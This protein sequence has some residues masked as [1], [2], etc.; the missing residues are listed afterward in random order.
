MSS[1]KSLAK[2]LPSPIRRRLGELRRRL[3]SSPSRTEAQKQLLLAD[4]ALENWQRELLTNVSSRIFYDDGMY[5]GDG[6]HY[7]KVGLSAIRCIDEA[8]RDA[9]LDRAESI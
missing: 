6:A 4:P 3:R 5:V 8:M 9:N 7:F 2:H 1:A